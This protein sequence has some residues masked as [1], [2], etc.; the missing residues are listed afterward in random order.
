MRVVSFDI[1]TRNLAYAVVDVGADDMTIADWGLRDIGKKTGLNEIVP[2]LTDWLGATFKEWDVVLIEN[3]IGSKMKTIQAVVS[4][5]FH[6]TKLQ[7]AQL[8]SNVAAKLKF[9]GIET[10]NMKY[11]DRKKAS[12]QYVTDRVFARGD[13]VSHKA[14]FDALKKKDDVSD[15]LMQGIKYCTGVCGLRWD[16]AWG[17]R[18]AAREAGSSPILNARA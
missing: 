7:P 6:V 12:V 2:P 9:T 14:W 3:Q 11:A 1:G 18:D 13:N 15:A 10:A 17:T 4:T 5:Y 8:V 16:F